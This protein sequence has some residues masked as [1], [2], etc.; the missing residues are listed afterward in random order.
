[1]TS[2]NRKD[3]QPGS[4]VQPHK[5]A[6]GYSYVGVH[7]AKD[8][9]LPT[10][11]D[12]AFVFYEFTTRGY[13]RGSYVQLSTRNLVNNPRFV[14]KDTIDTSDLVGVFIGHFPG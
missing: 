11:D 4:I 12:L 8:S 9:T 2:R 10:W 7:L 3:L 14:D 6:T 1:V 5:W 13:F